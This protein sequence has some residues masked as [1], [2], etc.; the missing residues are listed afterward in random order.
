MNQQQLMEDSLVI[1]DA[2]QQKVFRLSEK[3]KEVDQ[4]IACHLDRLYYT[5]HTKYWDY[6]HTDTLLS[7]QHPK[8]TFSDEMIFIVYHQITE[9]Y[10]K[11][12]ISEIRKIT[13]AK[14]ICDEDFLVGL[15][16]MNRYYENLIYSFDIMIDGLDQKQF[17]EFRYALWPASG[18]QS[19]QFREIELMATDLENLRALSYREQPSFE[20]GRNK[21]KELYNQ[22]YWK[23]GATDVTNGKRDLSLVHF[24][25]KYDWTL[26]NHA[27]KFENKNLWQ[28]FKN[29]DSK[30][31][32]SPEREKVVMEL[33]RLD[34]LANIDW[35]LAHYK[36][37]IRHLRT[38]V[39]VKEGTGGTNWQAYLP[40]RFQKIIFFPKLWTKQE[41]ENWGKTWV[42][43][44]LN[45]SFK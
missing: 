25:E 20:E 40:P 30:T 5:E 23:T 27:I 13:G 34:M 28:V 16:R 6:I 41:R 24:I 10:F 26:L 21:L 9:L 37:A 45:Q 43:G 3:Y 19:A 1:D 39:E 29:L 42:I 7:I 8:T 18:F 38:N 22:I 11:L 15:M 17:L 44:A 33:R 35:R 31:I 2:I 12:I 36:A 14:N 32:T 4:N